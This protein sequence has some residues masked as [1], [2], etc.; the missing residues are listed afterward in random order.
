MSL[1][2]KIFGVGAWTALSRVLGFV[3]DM[4]VGRFLGNATV[5]ATPSLS[6]VC[7]DKCMPYNS[8]KCSAGVFAE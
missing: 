8:S 6:C 4:L 3:R 2:K 7:V 5:T 1:A